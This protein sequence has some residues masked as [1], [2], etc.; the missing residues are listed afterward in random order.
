MTVVACGGLYGG[1]GETDT[2]S[3]T[4]SPCEGETAANQGGREK[5]EERTTEGDDGGMKKE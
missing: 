4:T 1:S 3:I 5:G 2:S